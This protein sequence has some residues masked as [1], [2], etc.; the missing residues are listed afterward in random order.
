MLQEMCDL[1]FSEIWRLGNHLQIFAPWKLQGLLSTMPAT[2]LTIWL[3]L[4]NTTATAELKMY[5]SMWMTLQERL[6]ICGRCILSR[7]QCLG[8]IVINSNPSVR[9]W[10]I[11]LHFHLVVVMNVEKVYPPA[12]RNVLNDS[13][14]ICA[15]TFYSSRLISLTLVIVGSQDAKSTSL[16]LQKCNSIIV[17]D[18]NLPK[19]SWFIYPLFH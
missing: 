8:W 17:K 1:I 5:I 13:T 11:V 14:T 6:L 7:I 2:Q 18:T 19:L 9:L 15:W 16:H 12:S 3:F 10:D 4:A